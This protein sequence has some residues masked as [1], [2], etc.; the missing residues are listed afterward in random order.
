[1]KMKDYKCSNCVYCQVTNNFMIRWCSC[2][3]K[4]TYLTSGCMRETTALDYDY[5]DYLDETD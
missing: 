5:D 4:V 3:N 2:W 1:M